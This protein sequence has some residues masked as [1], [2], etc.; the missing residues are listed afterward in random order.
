LNTNGK[1]RLE[2]G[3]KIDGVVPP[4]RELVAAFW[5]DRASFDSIGNR[6]TGLYYP[7]FNSTFN[8]RCFYQPQYEIAYAG[9]NGLDFRI[10]LMTIPKERLQAFRDDALRAGLS[11]EGLAA[12]EPV[13]VAYFVVPT[14]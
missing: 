2:W 11:G 10:E 1:V 3:T 8:G 12:F 4:D 14:E 7:F 6:G 5:P 9:G 13:P